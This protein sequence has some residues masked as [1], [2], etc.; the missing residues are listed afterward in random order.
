M[1]APGSVDILVTGDLLRCCCLFVSSKSVQPCSLRHVVP[2][3]VNRSVRCASCDITLN[4]PQQ[5]RQHYSGKAHQ[6]RLQKQLQQQTA[7]RP[8]DTEVETP[9]TESRDEEQQQDAERHRLSDGDD[10]ILRA[11]QHDD[12]NTDAGLI[13]T[14][15]SD[16]CESAVCL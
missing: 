11:A 3:R 10:G 8:T 16:E 1:S 9:T 5:A 4:S 6:R 12:V 13:A 7:F 14:T 2:S 15:Q